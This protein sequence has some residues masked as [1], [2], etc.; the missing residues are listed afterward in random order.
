MT[1]VLFASV[2]LLSSSVSVTV[3]AVDKSRVTGVLSERLMAE[4]LV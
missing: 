3:T 4:R 1:E 2:V